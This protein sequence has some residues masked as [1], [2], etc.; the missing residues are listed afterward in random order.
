MKETEI[1]LKLEKQLQYQQF[2]RSIEKMSDE[3]K[4]MFLRK[5]YYLYL[6]QSQYLQNI[7]GTI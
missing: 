6:G 4:N 3:Q 1:E 2:V 7:E 5:L